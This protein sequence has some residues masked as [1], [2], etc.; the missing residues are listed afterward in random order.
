M[1][2]FAAVYEANDSEDLTKL[3][4]LLGSGENLGYTVTVD[5]NKVKCNFENEE[6]GYNFTLVFKRNLWR[7]ISEDEF[8][9]KID[10]EYFSEPKHSRGLEKQVDETS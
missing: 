3:L 1:G 6:K 2:K 7:R 9:K 5:G 8:N 10:I 4:K